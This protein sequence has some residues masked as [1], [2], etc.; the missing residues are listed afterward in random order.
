[1]FQQYCFSTGNFY[2]PNASCPVGPSAL[3][4]F[5]WT[6]F[7]F[8][9]F[10]QLFNSVQQLQKPSP[11]FTSNFIQHLTISFASAT[12]CSGSS[13]HQQP[14]Q[15]SVFTIL[16]IPMPSS[17]HFRLHRLLDFLNARCHFLCARLLLQLPIVRF[18]LSIRAHGT[19]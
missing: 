17:I 7:L 10:L 5:C 12:S 11:A 4:L 18:P 2:P 16:Y 3:F 1:M 14:P 15:S 8:C 13:Q 19:R 6:L 9:F